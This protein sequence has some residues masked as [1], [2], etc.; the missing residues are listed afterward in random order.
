MDHVRKELSSY[1]VEIPVDEQ[2]DP[3]VQQ[4]MEWL[5]SSQLPSGG[6]GNNSPAYTAMAVKTIRQWRPAWR[7]SDGFERAALHIVSSASGGRLETVW[8]TAIAVSALE[9]SAAA[10]PFVAAATNYLT[11]IGPS[12]QLKPHHAAQLVITLVSAQPGCSTIP[13]WIAMLRTQRVHP[14][15]PYGL[16]QVSAALANASD[17]SVELRRQCDELSD[18]LGSVEI[19]KAN[20]VEYCS[21]L[22]GLSGSSHPAH[23]ARVSACIDDLFNDGRRLDGSWY[24]DPWETSWALAALRL[25]S[26]RKT[27]SMPVH[28]LA[29]VLEDTESLADLL[30]EEYDQQI[31]RLGSKYFWR[32]L[33]Y[34][35]AVLVLIGLAIY[36]IF[37]SSDS[38]WYIGFV[39]LLLVPGIPAA[40]R[41]W[42]LHS[43]TSRVD[44]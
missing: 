43:Q 34:S 21:A 30:Q 42:Q 4:S 35:Q 28:D 39:S 9:G 18:W 20:F 40:T 11:Q 31:A 38:G 12:T 6:F 22:I 44:A 32:V 16:G 1:I 14:A 41:L 26:A 36:G 33:A 25:A 8:D 15:T 5:I 2:S 3:R 24:H 19:T 10:H 29:L 27:V 23:A 37:L 17:A 7:Q 13:S